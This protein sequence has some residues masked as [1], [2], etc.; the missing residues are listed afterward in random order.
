M[1]Y[2]KYYSRFYYIIV[3]SQFLLTG[4]VADV[5]VLTWSNYSILKIAHVDLDAPKEAPNW[6]IN[7][8]LLHILQ[9]SLKNF[10][11]IEDYFAHYIKADIS[12]WIA[13]E[14]IL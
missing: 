3:N 4:H 14:Y 1:F 8:F 10:Q 11:Y 12:L 5:F 9:V 7:C 2:I 13:F 6:S